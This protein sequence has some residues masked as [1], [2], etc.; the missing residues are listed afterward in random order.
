MDPRSDLDLDL[1]LAN[2][3][4]AILGAGRSGL[5]AARLARQLGAVPVVFDEGDPVKLQ[6]AVQAIVDE[7]ID[8]RL[9]I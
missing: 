1:D 9:G 8:C 6:K 5:G 3:H 4:V 7:G 2:Q